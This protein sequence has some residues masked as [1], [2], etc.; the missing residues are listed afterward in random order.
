MI[1]PIVRSYGNL[2]TQEYGVLRVGED[3]HYA[4][5]ETFRH[6]TEEGR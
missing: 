3:E 2:S 1:D 6:T 4:F 5:I